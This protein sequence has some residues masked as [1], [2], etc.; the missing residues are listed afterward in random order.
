MKTIL[1]IEDEKVIGQNIT[2]ILTHKGFQAVYAANGIEGVDMATTYSPD[3][4]ICDIMMPGCDGYEVLNTLRQNPDTNAI[5]FIFLSA[6]V[7]KP[8]IRQGMNQGAD[9]YLTKPFT[10]AELLEAVHA[11]LDRQDAIAQPYAKEIKQ[12]AENLNYLAF[13]DALTDLPNLILLHQ[14]LQEQIASAKE[15]SD[16]ALLAIL[17]IHLLNQDWV[18]RKHAP[19]HSDALLKVIAERL[20]AFSQHVDS[21][22]NKWVARIGTNEFAL[23][24]SGFLVAEDVSEIVKP[25]I[26]DLEVPYELDQ[27]TTQLE[28]NIG[29]SLYPNSGTTAS[30]LLSNAEIAVHHCLTDSAM[31]YCLFVP[32]MAEAYSLRKKLL[33]D[34]Q[35]AL[36]QSEFHLV[37][38][39]QV[40]IIS[41]RITGVEALLRWQHPEMGAIAPDQFIPLAEEAQL[42]S[43]LGKWVIQTACMQMKGWRAMTLIPL[44]I[45]INLWPEQIQ[46]S[47]FLNHVLQSLRQSELNPKQLVLDISESCITALEFDA[48]A[49]VL[50]DIA[51][52]GI[53]IAIDGFGMHGIPLQHLKHLPIQI[54]KLDR[55]FINH[56]VD[57]EQDAI[58]TETIIAMA[59]SLKLKVIAKGI[60]TN[61]QLTVLTKYGCHM[62]QGYL[63]SPPLP[64]SEFEEV[65]TAGSSVSAIGQS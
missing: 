33:T 60:E 40:N 13:H 35:T 47:N 56:I 59:Q 49:Q 48:L 34:L 42:L 61:E 7:D 16:D 17:R 50:Q 19:S 12:A 53:Q 1:V 51:A 4:I 37:Y 2:K 65:L 10:S 46:D 23:V 9:D 55:S 25:L 27:G 15:S 36:E 26:T 28:V 43:K 62:M 44:Q 54:L 24:V 14:R 45:S 21:S 8:D 18:E 30:T 64:P 22:L 5:P 52:T 39:P 29:A 6:R 41:E 58:M 57:D 20:K 32:E 63:Y 11:R 31:S 38:Q 3:L